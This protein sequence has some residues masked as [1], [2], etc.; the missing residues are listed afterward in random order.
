MHARA[1]LSPVWQ[2]HSREVRGGGGLALSLSR[3]LTAR[4]PPETWHSCQCLTSDSAHGAAL[5][6]VGL[7]SSLQAA[8]TRVQ[9]TPTRADQQPTARSSTETGKIK[10][11]NTDDGT[12]ASSPRVAPI[13][14]SNATFI[15]QSLFEWCHVIAAA[16]LASAGPKSR[17]S[18]SSQLT[19]LCS[20]SLALAGST[21]TANQATH[22]S[23]AAVLASARRAGAPI[24]PLKSETAA[25]DEGR[26]AED[27]GRAT[28]R[29]CIFESQMVRCSAT[30]CACARVLPGL[31][32]H[33]GGLAVV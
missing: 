11:T 30:P 8:R 27:Q 13:R 26:C 29:R 6:N 20:P 21:S 14:S 15:Q 19:R 32:P 7:Y 33:G 23:T 2:Q 3:C 1:A 10:I 4:Q 12:H 22:H 28:A 31:C 25:E 16:P 24:T 18:D 17:H 5:V 9:R